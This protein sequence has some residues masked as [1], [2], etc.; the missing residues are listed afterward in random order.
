MVTKTKVSL[1]KKKS[2]KPVLLSLE[3]SVKKAIT[4]IKEC[5]YQGKYIK[6]ELEGHINRNRRIWS[7]EKCEDF[8]KENVSPEARRAL[9]FGRFYVD[10]SVDS[11]YTFTVPID[12]VYYVL[13]YIEAF[14]KLSEIASDNSVNKLDVRGAGMHIAILNDPDGVYPGGNRLN[15]YCADS[16]RYSMNKLLPAL[17][18]LGTG[19]AK[20]RPLGYRVP[21][22]DLRDKYSAITGHTNVFEYRVFDTCYDNPKTFLD[23]FCVIAKTMQFYSRDK[24]VLPFFD[25]IGKLQ[26]PDNG[27]HLSRFYFTANHIKALD[28]GLAILKPDHKTISQLKKERNFTITQTKLEKEDKQLELDLESEFQS[29]SKSF[30]EHIEDRK[31]IIS[32][33]YDREKHFVPELLTKTKKEVIDEEVNRL[34]KSNNHLIDKKKYIEDKKFQKLNS[35]RLYTVTV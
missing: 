34:L 35:A 5:P 27:Y 28:L 19:N 2:I 20:S 10:G 11:E 8:M 18:F 24:I 15:A 17:Y 3:D 22:V 26:I 30:K 4:T 13:E 21:K 32:D 31:K 29:K 6:V 25:T 7:N 23:F 16:F 14:K 12:G 1:K 9:V 33:W